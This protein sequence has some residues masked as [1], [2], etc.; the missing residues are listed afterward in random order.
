MKPFAH[1]LSDGRSLTLWLSH[2]AKKNII[3]RPHGSDSL[4]INIPPYL[5]QARLTAWLAANEA[6]LMRMLALAPPPD[7][8]RPSEIWYLGRKLPLQTHEHTHADFSDNAFFL[9][10]GNWPEQRQALH[11]LLYR[12]AQTT[13][14]P[15]LLAQAQRLNLH[16]AAV[17][18]SRAKTFWG[19]C[20]SQ[21]GIKLNWRLI[22]APD[23]VSEY[24]CIHELCHLTH[25]NHSPAFWALVNRHTPHTA[26]A[27]QWLKQHGAELFAM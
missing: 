6:A 23:W 26:Q 2:S 4:R 7:T 21:T 25:P 11:K 15:Q 16:P 19:V 17:S 20:R 9:P 14:L 12:Q 27:K 22:G 10:Q 1:R 8:G 3:L 5:S 18:L 24:V 13:L